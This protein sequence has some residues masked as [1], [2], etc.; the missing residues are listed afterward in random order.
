MS[1]VATIKSLEEELKG[2]TL[3]DT[4]RR[5]IADNDAEYR[6]QI[7]ESLVMRALEGNISA[8][9]LLIELEKALDAAE[10]ETM[11]W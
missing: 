6:K 9:R 7:A 2:E 11:T 1:V 3:A 5:M 10:G 8:I 4:I